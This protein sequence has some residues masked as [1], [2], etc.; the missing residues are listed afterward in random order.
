MSG[1]GPRNLLQ[2]NLIQFP[3][4]VNDGD[5]QYQ[6]ERSVFTNSLR[7][8][9]MEDMTNPKLTP[10]FDFTSAVINGATIITLN[11]VVSISQL[12]GITRGRV[13]LASFQMGGNNPSGTD[14]QC[15]SLTCSGNIQGQTATVS[16]GLSCG[17]LTTTLNAAGTGQGLVSCGGLMAGTGAITGGSVT[18]SGTIQGTNFTAI[19]AP[20]G[21]NPPLPGGVTGGLFSCTS[22]LVKGVD[23]MTLLA[24]N[25]G[26]TGPTGNT[27]QMGAMGQAG[28]VGATGPQGA[29]GSSA[30]TLNTAPLVVQ[31]L[32]V[33][34][35][36]TPATSNSP[37]I[38]NGYIRVNRQDINHQIG[39]INFV[40]DGSLSWKRNG[41]VQHNICDSNGNIPWSV[42]TGVPDLSGGSAASVTSTAAG[43]GA[44]VGALAGFFGGILGS[45]YA[46]TS[47]D[48]TLMSQAI[49]SAGSSF[50][51]QLGSAASQLSAFNP[52]GQSGTGQ[53]PANP[54]MNN[55]AFDPFLGPL[56]YDLIATAPSPS[57]GGLPPIGSNYNMNPIPN[58]N[59]PQFA[60]NVWESVDLGSRASSFGSQSF[61]S[62]ADA[63]VG[64][65]GFNVANRY[66][67][68]TSSGTG[69]FG[70]ALPTVGT[71]TTGPGALANA[72]HQMFQF[73]KGAFGGFKRWA[74]SAMP[75]TVPSSGVAD[76]VYRLSPGVT[77]VASTGSGAAG[78][79]PMYGLPV[80]FGAAI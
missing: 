59:F 3:K 66:G 78:V 32:V 14:I 44:G 64:Q 42:L 36:D 61:Q 17:Y 71:N 47:A 68:A 72:S 5:I 58:A 8:T 53:I 29:P 55:A 35:T 16:Q 23:L 48:G 67:S 60:E 25:P 49:T 27:G 1:Y 77:G 4:K 2:A 54:W 24:N 18:V 69:G 39:C 19:M 34:G 52:L 30:Q 13:P 51:S 74:L 63:G 46:A 12:D 28:A 15:T 21:G 56:N 45:S 20:S 38:S 10:V 65:A 33:N 43:S 37:M 7:D 70:N 50:S 31:S 57:Q 80:S 76:A 22:L 6:G 11:K 40:S 9:Y 41:G 26:M 75:N 73:S 79:F 62:Q